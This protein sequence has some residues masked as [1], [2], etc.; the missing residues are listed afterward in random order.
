MHGWRH[1]TASLLIAGG[2]DVKT[3]QARMGHS[4]PTITLKLY[5]DVVDERDRAAGERLAGYL[6]AANKPRT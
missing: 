4:T 6:P 1:S 3:T 5:T 2:T